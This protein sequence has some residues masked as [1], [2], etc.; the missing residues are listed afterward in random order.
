MTDNVKKEFHL[1]RGVKYK[2]CKECTNLIDVRATKC[3]ECGAF[4]NWRG[5]LGFAAILVSII[6]GG[7]SVFSTSYP[8]VK[9]ILTAEFEVQVKR[10]G[11][12][13]KYYT[14]IVRN[15]GKQPVAIQ[16]INI[17]Y[18]EKL[19][20]LEIKGDDNV[21]PA[22][23]SRILRLH[24]PFDFSRPEVVDFLRTELDGT[25]FERCE[26]LIALVGEGENEW[27]FLEENGCLE[28]DDFLTGLQTLG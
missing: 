25:T 5:H 17:L 10:I 8:V 1:S 24:L 21:I 14:V 11:V 18:G 20:F 22:M 2:A 16:Y 4:Q 27:F 6:L 9:E 15:L 12:N 23:N 28:M 19:E 7:I 26:I 3:K 13:A